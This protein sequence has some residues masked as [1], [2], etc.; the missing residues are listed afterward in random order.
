[1]KFEE[2]KK[3]VEKTEETKSLANAIK[4]HILVS[5]EFAILAHEES[6]FLT[7]VLEAVQIIRTFEKEKS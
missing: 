7:A 5:Y 1:M 4:S 6:E 3:E 2:L